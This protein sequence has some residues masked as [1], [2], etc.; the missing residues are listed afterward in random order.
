[1]SFTRGAHDPSARCAGTSPRKSVG[2]RSQAGSLSRAS[3]IFLKA[4]RAWQA[5]SQAFTLGLASNSSGAAW[6]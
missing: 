3:H 6:A 5:A 2:R 4:G 1:M